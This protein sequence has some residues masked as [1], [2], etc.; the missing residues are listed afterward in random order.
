MTPDS[1]HSLRTP[2]PEFAEHLVVEEQHG[3]LV[4][5][6]FSYPSARSAGSRVVWDYADTSLPVRAC[7]AAFNPAG[8]GP[9]RVD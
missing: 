3:G 4:V 1:P 5:S 2:P 9:K 8:V 7:A 6:P